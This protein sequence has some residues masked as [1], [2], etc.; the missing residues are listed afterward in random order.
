MADAFIENQNKYGT[1]AL[2]MIG[3]AANE[4]AWGCSRIAAEKNNLFGHTNKIKILNLNV[5]RYY[6]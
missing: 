5:R 4:S 6:I 1:N 2:L 3:V